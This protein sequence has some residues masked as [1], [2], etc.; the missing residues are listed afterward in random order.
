MRRMG[1][2]P[3]DNVKETVNGYEVR[4]NILKILK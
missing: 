1:I 3:E 4:K 2:V